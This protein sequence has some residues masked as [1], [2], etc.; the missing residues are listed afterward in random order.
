MATSKKSLKWLRDN[1]SF[2]NINKI[3]KEL[4]MPSS[5]LQKALGGNRGLPK[6]WETPVNEFVKKLKRFNDGR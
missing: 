4:D 5:T 2:L 1:K 6:I 3:E